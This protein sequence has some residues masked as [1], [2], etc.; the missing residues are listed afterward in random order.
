MPI[1]RAEC[2]SKRGLR[3]T[4]MGSGKKKA[5]CYL[6]MTIRIKESIW[7]K[8]MRDGCVGLNH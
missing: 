7:F 2:K 5:V 1:V 6:A 4:I 3:T 8:G